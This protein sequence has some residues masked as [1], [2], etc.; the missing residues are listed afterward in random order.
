MVVEEEGGP[1]QP[2]R[3]LAG[4]WSTLDR[5]ELVEGGTD[6]LVLLGLNGGD[7]VEHLARTRPLELGQQRVAAAQSGG[8]GLA[9]GLAE[10]VVGDGHDRADDRP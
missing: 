4:A 1:V 7:D 10:E 9:A 3:G 8:A 5:Q 6:D 2:D